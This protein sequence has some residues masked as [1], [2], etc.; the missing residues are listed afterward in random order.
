MISCLNNYSFL[1]APL[2]LSTVYAPQMVQTAATHLVFNQ[3]KIGTLVPTNY[4]KHIHACLKCN[5]WV[6]IHPLCSMIWTLE[7]F[8]FSVT[9]VYSLHSCPDLLLVDQ[10]AELPTAIRAEVS[11]FTF[12][13]LLKTHS[14]V[15]YLDMSSL[16]TPV[17]PSPILSGVIMDF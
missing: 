10:A 6:C 8:F 4:P 16:P 9:K 14:F 2:T 12:K 5:F 17:S 15:T 11:Y 1:L 7:W 13:N 3:P